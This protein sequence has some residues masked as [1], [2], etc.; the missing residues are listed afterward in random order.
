MHIKKF[1]YL[2]KSF[3]RRL[4]TVC[5]PLTDRCRVFAQLFSQPLI[6]LLSVSQYN[7]YP[8]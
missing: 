8:I 4:T 6:G 3:E 1:G 5:A 2:H 7:L